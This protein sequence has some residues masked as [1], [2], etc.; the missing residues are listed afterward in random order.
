MYTRQDSSFKYTDSE[1]VPITV[2]P[3]RYRS[4]FPFQNFNLMQSKSFAHIYESDDN[5]V[6]SSPTG[7]GKTVLFELAVIKLLALS[8]KNNQ[9]VNSKAIYMAPT[10]ALCKERYDDWTE[11]FQALDCKVGLLTSDTTLLEMESVKRSTIVICTPEKWDAITRR[12]NDYSKMLD[13]VKLLLIDEVHFLREK[14][15]TS[16]EVVTTRM[17]AMANNLR[18]IALSATVPNIHDV[19]NWLTDLNNPT[20]QTQTLIYGDN[21]RSVKINK[22]VYGYRNGRPNNN[23]QFDMF[24]NNKLMEVVKNHSKGKPVMVFCSTRMNATQTAKKIAHD[25]PRIPTGHLNFPREINNEMISMIEHGACYHHAGLSLIERKYIEAL[26]K[27]GEIKVLCSTSTLSVGVNLPAYLVIIKGTQQWAN[28]CMQEYSELDIMQM[29]GRAGRP[30]F[31]TEGA[32]VIMT[33]ES[34]KGK[35]ERLVKGTEKL[36]STLH[37][38]IYEHITAEI[39]L[40]T[41]TNLENSFNWLK[42]TFL[43]QRFKLNPMAYPSISSKLIQHHS[44]DIQLQLFIK[45][46]LGELVAEQMI[47][48]RDHEYHI[49]KYGETMSKNYVMYETM[50]MLLKSPQNMSMRQIL[51]SV[52]QCKE[53][54]M[55]KMKQQNKKLY[56][57]I[58]ENPLIM[59]PIKDKNIDQRSHKVNLIIQFELSGLEFP[60]FNGA[61]KG[62]YDFLIE[63][64]MVFKNVPRILKAAIDVYVEKKDASTLVKMMELSRCIVARTWEKSSQVLKQFDGIGPVYAKQLM[65]KG[66]KT[67]NDAKTKLTRDKLEHFLGLKPGSGAK[68]MRSI[69]RSPNLDLEID[70]VKLTGNKVKFKVKVILKNNLNEVNLRANGCMVYISVVTEKGGIV[71]DFRRLPLKKAIGVK[72]FTLETELNSPN[73][74][75]IV[76]LNCDELA[77]LGKQMKIE[78]VENYVK[79]LYDKEIVSPEV[80]EM[81]HDDEFSDDFVE[82]EEDNNENRGPDISVEKPSNEEIINNGIPLGDLSIIECSHKCPDKSVCRHYCCKHGI[83]RRSRKKCKHSC[84]DKSQCR[85]I[86]CREQFEYEKSLKAI[87]SPKQRTLETMIKIN[88]SSNE[89]TLSNSG[90]DIFQDKLATNNSD[91]FPVIIPTSSSDPLVFSD[92]PETGVDIFEDKIAQVSKTELLS[93]VQKQIPEP[94]LLKVTEKKG[95]EFPIFF[96]KIV[97]K[98]VKIPEPIEAPSTI[99]DKPKKVKKYTFASLGGKPR[100][101]LSNNWKITSKK[102]VLDEFSDDFNED[103]ENFEDSLRNSLKRIKM[104]TKNTHNSG[105]DFA[106][107]N[108]V[109]T[110]ANQEN[111]LISVAI[112]GDVAVNSEHQ[113]DVSFSDVNE[114]NQTTIYDDEKDLLEFLGSDIEFE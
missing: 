44:I 66:I 12:W 65:M 32:C 87:P 45:D 52:S 89:V 22:V 60:T 8:S 78:L 70:Q 48:M 20:T 41:I 31:E 97:N 53:F 42:S 109:P 5:C 43:Y 61:M 108:S 58:N 14:R 30:Q 112:P 96:E 80:I 1:T 56:K 62:H 21:Y 18:I 54:D 76:Y 29:M 59:Y 64:M 100:D 77:G 88:T 114:T 63:K 104:T 26:F 25:S 16:L 79:G 103:F 113:D 55:L 36:E 99:Y 7:S 102:R 82:E 86:C 67:M 101:F 92:E 4:I 91:P 17:K 49:T 71:L 68:M 83:Q 90:M 93:Q 105:V 9:F 94:K 3:E 84:K 72:S 46:I 34:K 23:F 19:S 81:N 10:K 69:E 33:D 85:H 57:S 11:K 73:D 75:I 27:K 98:P 107:V 110:P 39:S 106:I 51:E 24:L 95:S 6:I 50:K 40:G 74:H 28:Q 37:L 47:V 2:L 38:N 15:G 13:Y 111:E 35:Y